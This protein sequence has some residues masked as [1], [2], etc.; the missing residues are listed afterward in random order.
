MA[1]NGRVRPYDEQGGKPF[2]VNLAWLTPEQRKLWQRNLSHLSEWTQGSWCQ[3]T[4]LELLDFS[5]LCVLEGEPPRWPP[6]LQATLSEYGR[7]VRDY[8]ANVRAA[9]TR[10]DL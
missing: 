6:W 1:A 10:G 7:M 5:Y 3:A 9:R 2:V 4:C 8:M